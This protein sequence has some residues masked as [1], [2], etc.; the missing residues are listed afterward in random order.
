MAE[1]AATIPSAAAGHERDALL[2][3][4]LHVPGPRPGLVSRPRLLERLADGVG[5]AMVLVSTPAGFGKTTLLAEWARRAQPPV[6]WLSLDEADNDPTRFWR[7]VA[8]ALDGVRPGVAERVA[9]L[10]DG[11]R[12]AS[13]EPVAATLVNQLAGV[14]EELVLVVDDYH[15]VQAPPVHASME[16]LLEHLPASLRLVMASR[17]DPP[18]RLAR[19]RARGQLTELREADLRFTVQEAAELLRAGVGPELPEPAVAALEDRTEGWVAGLQLAVLS[20]QGHSDPAAFVA[21][22]SGSHRY[23]LDY[24]AEEVL[25]RQPERLRTFLLETAVLARL[26]GPLCDAVT[27]RDDSQALLEQLERANLFLVALDEVRGWWRYHQLF[28][29]LLRARLRRDRPDRV[30]ELHRAAA[31]WFEARRLADDAVRHALAAGDTATAARLVDQHAQERLERGEGATLQTWLAALGADLV[32][33]RPR[34]CLAQ[35]VIALIDGRLDEVEVQLTQTERA[36]D[37]DRSPGGETAKGLANVP[38][39]LAMMRAELAHRGDG[40]AGRTIRLARQGLAVTD[41]EDRYLGFHLRWNLA[42]GTLLEGRV[43]EAEAALADLAADPW[44]TGPRCYLTVRTRRTL[45]QVHRAQG[46]LGAA[47]RSCQQALELF[48]EPTGRPTVPAA[49]LAYVGMAEV[50]RERGELDAALDHATEGVALCRQLAYGQWLGTSLS[51]LAWIRTAFGDQAGAMAAIGE[52]ERSVPDPEVIADLI[53]PV[54]VQRARLWLADGEIAEAARWAHRRGLD[55]GDEPSFAREREHLVL[56]RVLVAGH[57][58]ERALPLLARLH[59][60]AAA[61]QRTGSVIEVQALR[62]LALDAAGDQRGATDTLA[63]ALRLAAP[64]GWVRVFVD[65][66]A[67]MAVLVGRLATTPAGGWAAAAQAPRPFLERLVGAFARS[68]LPVPT[69]TRRGGTI[70]AGLVEPLTARELEVLELLAAGT[71]NRQIAEELVVSE[72]TVKKHVSHLL[73][74]LGAANRTQAVARARALGLL[75]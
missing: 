26:S 52:A 65:E 10:L 46:R 72:E 38:G 60:L 43:A 32:C 61:Q 14:A 50:L 44:A 56:A 21:S 34:L 49:A 8:A 40:D 75:G 1:P 36:Y 57:T 18:L 69:R 3:T 45:A 58:P 28:A 24:L 33:S 70:V 55:P 64:E 15:L 41:T 17:T 27:G 19:L 20:L 25:D 71:S 4:K 59:D 7:H 23:V 30:A 37:A 66:G 73:D 9:G 35:A 11:L 63:E 31:A 67:P 39:M 51:V 48:A 29:D 16:F 62:A 2:A 53:L 54:A 22:F 6:A 68:G 13:F 5:Q 42:V 12:A 74:K 47:L